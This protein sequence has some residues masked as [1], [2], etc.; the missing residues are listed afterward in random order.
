MLHMSFPQIIGLWQLCIIVTAQVTYQDSS[1]TI[2]RVDNGTY[3][4][5]IEEVHYYYDQWPIGLAV[6]STGRIFVD[7]T[8]G[9]Y[10]YTL[11]E[12]VNKTTE[13]PYPDLASQ[14]PVDVLANSSSGVNFATNNSTGLISVQAL[15]ITSKTSKRPETLWV[16]DTGRPTLADGTMPYALPGG[17]KLIAMDISDDT[18]YK[19]YT[20]P[21]TV[22]F[23]D[24]YLNDVRIDFN[25]NVTESGQGIAYMVDSSSEGRNGF[26]MLDLGTGES[27]R[28]LTLHPSTLSVQN[29]V[30]SYLGVPFYQVAPKAK[31]FTHVQEGIDGIQLSPAGD[32]IYYSPL[33]SNYLY[34]IESKYLRDH[35]SAAADQN[36]SNNVKNLGQRGGDGNGFEGDS[37][38]LI[39]QLIPGQNSIVA[40][41]PS[42]SMN[43]GFVRDPRIIWPDSASVAEDGYFYF[44]VNQAS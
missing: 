35:T 3:G 23:I 32:I 29:V 25:P 19:T 9:S 28:Q 24:S 27:W 41:D 1:S 4:P 22:H 31:Q 36:A 30:D 2:L 40:W 44:N 20:F 13:K 39:Y 6:S 42:K 34:S 8:R 12:V 16:L 15:I 43:V 18:V 7:Y 10:P 21:E 33:T 11:G 26:I 37:N 17:P 38:G 14:V 5:A